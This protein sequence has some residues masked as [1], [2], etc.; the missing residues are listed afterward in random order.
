MPVKDY[1]QVLNIPVGVGTAEIKKAFR[2]LAM[3]YHP[4]K[5]QD[6]SQFNTYFREI[7]EAYAILADPVKREQYH[8]QRWLEKSMGHE[9]D[10]SLSADQILALFIKAE[11]YI[12]LSDKFRLNKEL[13]LQQLLELY[14]LSR[15]YTLNREDNPTI[16]KEVIKTAM[17]ISSNLNSEGAETLRKHVDPL[18]QKNP[19]ELA[20]WGLII[21]KLKQQEKMASLTIPIAILI[22][23]LLCLMLYF[24]NRS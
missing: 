14:S 5:Q 8:Y 19:E 20:E 6:S 16:N 17:R 1:Y 10:A 4:D 13:L 18:L 3:T 2:K 24:M 7:Q 22:T 12:A 9:L 15:L 11:Q 23:L 21:L